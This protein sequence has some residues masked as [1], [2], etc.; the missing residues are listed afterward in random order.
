MSSEPETL[1]NNDGDNGTPVAQFRKCELVEEV[2]RLFGVVRLGVTGFSMLPS[3]WPGDTLII[4]RRSIEE[5]A[6]GDI[7]LYWRR[8]RLVAHRVISAADSLGT[9][10]VGV[11]G[12]ALPAPDDL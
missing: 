6:V 12:D 10:N 3:V 1:M 4:L 5:V 2:L 11:Q 9:S 8:A 7:V